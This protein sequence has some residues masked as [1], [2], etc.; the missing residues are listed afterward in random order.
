MVS[1]KDQG[2][3][4]SIA[5]APSSGSQTTKLPKLTNSSFSSEYTQWVAFWDQFTILVDSKVD[6]ANVE[7]L[8]QYNLSLKGIAAQIVSSM[9]VADENN[10]I[11]KRMLEER[12]NNKRSIVKA[13]LAAIHALSAIKK[14][15]SAKLRK[16]LES[17]NEHVQ[18]LEAW[19]LPVDQWDALLMFLLLE[20]LK[21][22]SRKQFILTHLGTDVLTFK[23]L[24]IFMNGRCRALASSGEQPEASVPKTTPKKVHQEAYSSTVEHTASCQTKECT[25]SHQTSHCDRHKQL[26]TR[27]RKPVVRKLKRCTNCL[28][29][30]F[31]TDCPSKFSCRRKVMWRAVQ[32]SVVRN[33]MFRALLDSG[34]QTSFI[35]ADAA[36]KFNLVRSTVDVKISGIGGRQEAANS[37]S[38]LVGPQK[39]SV[40]A[41]VLYSIADNISSQFA[42]LKQLKSMKNVVLANKN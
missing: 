39:M 10:D 6:M 12:F 15:S 30:H 27:E 31:V 23:K 7:K 5:A 32:L 13:H 41:L 38:L 36:S 4:T 3:T 40:T 28:G 1:G 19:M 34:S 25:G 35:T 9:L 21:A 22:E 8:S 17:T 24:T 18:A 33:I 26:G 11:A 37:A 2:V 16:L 20:K 14:E 42:N 29:Q